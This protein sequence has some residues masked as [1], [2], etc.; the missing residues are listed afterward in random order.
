MVHKKYTLIIDGATVKRL[1]EMKQVIRYVERAFGEF[2]R[3]RT[4]MPAKI[5]LDL[6]KYSGDFRAMPAFIDRMDASVLKWVNVHT[7]NNRKG[8]PTVMATMI[9]SDPKTGY[10]LAIMDATY[11]TSLRTAA[12]GAVAAKYCARQDSRIVGL[13]GCGAQAQT[14][15]TALRTLFK[16][17]EIRVWGNQAGQ[18]RRFIKHMRVKRERMVC[19]QT[20]RQCVQDCDIVVTTTPSRKPLV[21][22]KWLKEGVHINAI[23]ADAPGKQELDMAILRNAKIII[24]DWTQAAHSGEINVAFKKRL[25]TKRSIYAQIGDIVIGR[26][27]GRR[28]NQDITVFD[29]TG[30]AIQDAAMA[31]LIYES[32]VQKKAGKRF[33]FID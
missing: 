2:A 12:A 3:N 30:L 7:L 16:F 9:L 21:R 6:K 11:A 32:A 33:S 17:D 10:P 19:A 27:K 14:Q 24:D 5:Y 1:I 28:N 22:L 29:S 4:Q 13:V 8:L 15:L 23:G 31:K 25:I 18:A 26:R 20:V